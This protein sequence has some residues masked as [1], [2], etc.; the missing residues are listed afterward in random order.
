MGV[1][2]RVCVCGHAG[3]LDAVLPGLIRGGGFNGYT[4]WE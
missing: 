4:H 1:C 2:V 3:H